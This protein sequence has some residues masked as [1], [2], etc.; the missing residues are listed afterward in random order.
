MTG[1]T[2]EASKVLLA[3]VTGDFVSHFPSFSPI[4]SYELKGSLLVITGYQYIIIARTGQ[5]SRDDIYILKRQS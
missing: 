3:G 5:R 4:Y 1:A 2:Y